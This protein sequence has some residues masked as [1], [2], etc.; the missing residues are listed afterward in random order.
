MVNRLGVP[1][2]LHAS[3]YCPLGLVHFYWLFSCKTKQ[4]HP[5]P[6]GTDAAELLKAGP[7][8]FSLKLSQTAPI[9][10]ARG[11]EKSEKLY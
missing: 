3:A 4:V 7:A 11:T 6:K 2:I 9:F 8:A 5:L 1:H 10:P